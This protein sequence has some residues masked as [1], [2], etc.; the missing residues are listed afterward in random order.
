MSDIRTKTVDL[1][2]E[3][4]D[5]ESRLSQIAQEASQTDSDSDEWDSLESEA[6]S[7]KARLSVFER[8]LED[9]GNGRF[10]IKE[11]TFGELM[12]AKDEV[13]AAS[14]EMNEDELDGVPKDGFYRVKVLEMG[15]VDQPDSAPRPAEFPYHVGEWLYDE[16]DE[17]NA[18]GGAELEDF[19]LEEMVE[20]EQMSKSPQP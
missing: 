15:I 8:K 2:R 17:L 9:W 19:S 4:Q 3:I 7:L 5:I 16:I 11:M 13:L 20:N 1:Q 14:F 6:K 18:A 10:E 12:H